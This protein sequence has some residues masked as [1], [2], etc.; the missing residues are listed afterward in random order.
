MPRGE[1]EETISLVSP[2]FL[3]MLTSTKVTSPLIM[4]SQNWAGVIN[5]LLTS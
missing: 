1:V 2:N 5:L 4:T 3:V